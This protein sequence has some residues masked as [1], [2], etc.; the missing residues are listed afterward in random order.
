MGQLSPGYA[1]MTDPWMVIVG[2]AIATFAIRLGGI[3]LGQGLPKNGSWA[4]A[5]NALPGCLIVALVS[6][7]LLSGGPLE[8]LAGAIAAVVAIFTRSLPL[9]M[10]VGIAAIWLLR[11]F[12]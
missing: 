10:A 6:V 1:A 8:W 2:L 4:R 3:Y 12:A 5:L 9:T 7:S 11:N